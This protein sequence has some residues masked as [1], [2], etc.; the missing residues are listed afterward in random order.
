[1]KTKI[2]A[3]VGEGDLVIVVTPRDLTDPRDPSKKYR[4]STYM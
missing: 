4:A 2:V 3:V 1:M